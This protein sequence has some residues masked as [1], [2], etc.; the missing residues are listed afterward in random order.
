M[1]IRVCACLV[2]SSC[3]GH[4]QY[5]RRALATNESPCTETL[6]ESFGSGSVGELFSSSAYVN[7]AGYPRLKLVSDAFPGTWGTWVAPAQDATVIEFH[8]SFRFSFKNANGGPGDGFSFLWGD[9]SETSGTRMSGGEWGV[10]AFVADGAGLSIGFASYPA[11]GAN[12]VNGRWGGT[13]FA[14]EPFAYDLVRYDDYEVAADPLNMATATVSWN[15]DTGVMVTIA[16]PTFP[17]QVIHLDKGQNQTEEIDPT[18]WSFGF[19]SRNGEIDQ[20]VLIG[21]LFI[22]TEVACPD[23]SIPADLDGDCKVHGSDLGLL[24][25]NWGVCGFDRCIGDINQDGGVDGGDLG[26]M[27]SAWG[28][29]VE[30]KV[31]FPAD[32]V[33]MRP[34]GTTESTQG[35][36]EYLPDQYGSRNDWALMITLHGLGENGSGSSLELDR[37]RSYGPQSLIASNNWPLSISSAG[38]EFVILSPQNSSPDCHDPIEIDAFIRYAIDVYGIDPQRVY[39]TGLSCGGIGTWEYLRMFVQDDLLAAVVPICGDGRPAF[40]Q[41]GCELGAVPIWAFHGDQ[42]DV[43][44]VEGT[45]SPMSDLDGCVDP[46]AIDLMTTIY[47]GVGH[48]SWSAT[49]DLSAGNDIYAW[50]LSHR[51]E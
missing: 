34:K 44:L 11:A 1:F 43:V 39:L 9:L 36:W 38:D 21:D 40:Q 30:C 7:V 19:S 3:F 15:R 50:M 20:D 25:A 37:V 49:Y 31:G 35:Y 26:Q 14:F 32:R 46:V 13:D 41:R 27:L 47:R 2:L 51:N 17:P 28:E 4:E 48:D 6:E 23:T 24:L 18:G 33:S 10:E 42:D 29:E 16:L 8:V 22:T 12:G 45:L 5:V